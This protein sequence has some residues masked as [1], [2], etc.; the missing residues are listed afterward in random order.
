[1][2]NTITFGCR[3]NKVLAV[4]VYTLFMFFVCCCG[5]DKQRMKP[6]YGEKIG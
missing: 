1:M 2:N 5:E 3:R 4:R 6:I